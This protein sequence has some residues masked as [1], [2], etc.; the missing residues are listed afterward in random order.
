M[1]KLTEGIPKEELKLL[2]R[3][4]W[5][6]Q[7]Y[8]LHF[9]YS[10]WCGNATPWIIWPYLNW[11]YPNPE[12]KPK[13][14]KALK[15]EQG[16]MNINPQMAP[17]MYSL[18][19]RLEKEARDNPNF[20][21]KSIDAVRAG[22]QGPL[23]GVGDAIWWVTWRL[24]A[25]GLALPFSNQGNLLG[26]IIFFFGLNI[27]SYMFRYVVLYTSYKMG[28]EI[29]T[30]AQESGIFDKLI[31]GASIV[32][33]IMIGYMVAS[34][35]AVPLDVSFHILDENYNI[36]EMINDIVPGIL[37]LAVLALMMKLLRKN[38]RIMTIIFGLMAICILFSFI[39]IF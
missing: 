29:I 2:R 15:R 17:I 6:S 35:V 31:R 16:L 32:G 37:S 13:K 26:P 21:A 23:S 10:R 1:S 5:R 3:I 27:P 18:F 20:D 30:K 14:L 22:L 7:S 34:Y 11:L 28:S 24:L 4:Y 39:G 9:C 19:C 8:A 12:D 36:L 25:T 33:L 38:V